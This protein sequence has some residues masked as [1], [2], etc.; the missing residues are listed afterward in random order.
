[1]SL[2]ETKEEALEI[3]GK[4][5][6]K[7]SVVIP[8]TQNRLDNLDR[9]L[10]S[11]G[12]QTYP[13]DRITVVC[14]GWVPRTPF[15]YYGQ[16]GYAISINK[17]EPG[18]EPP[19]NV[20][21]R[22]TDMDS[23]YVWFLDSDVIVGPDTLE[24]YYRAFCVTRAFDK[25]MIGPYEWMPPGK[26]EPDRE[27][28][29]DPRWDMFGRFTNKSVFQNNLGVALGNFSGN[30]VWPKHEFKRIG[31][32]WWQ[33][34]AGR[35]DDGELGIRAAAMGIPMVLV[36]EARGWHIAHEVN[37]QWVFE[38]NAREVPMINERHPYIEE[39]GLIVRD[40]DG[41]RFN[42]VC[43]NC[44]EEINTLDIWKHGEKCPTIYNP[45]PF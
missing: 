18:Q 14:D 33:L 15:D 3:L 37:A 41:K 35:V 24:A 43:K 42:I 17:H 25:V 23:N 11:L 38:T 6:F 10:Q 9:V 7:V 28:R 8:A 20:G 36:P 12:E 45:I 4:R 30:L 1:M 40:H 29:N 31:G 26:T 34:S 32:F 39:Q 16:E 2:A 22:W 21:V 19:R 27:L 44:G 13:I 5:N